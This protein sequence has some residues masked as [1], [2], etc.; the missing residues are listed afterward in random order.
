M[1]TL[2]FLPPEPG[3]YDTL[4]EICSRCTLPLSDD[5][6]DET[7]PE[8]HAICADQ[9]IRENAADRAETLYERFPR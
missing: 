7:L 8:M 9:E 4:P 6:R 5:D 3:E 2:R 1:T